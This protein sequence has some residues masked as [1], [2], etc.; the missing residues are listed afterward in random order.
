MNRLAIN[1]LG[2]ELEES[3]AYCRAEGIG[4][5]ITDFAFPQN[6]DDDLVAQIDR[7]VNALTGIEPLISHGPFFDLVVTSIDP[8][9]VGISRQRHEAALRAAKE[10]GVSYYV[11]H[12]NFTPLIRDPSYRG[13]W[14]TRMLNFWLPIADDAGK[15]NIVIC[16]ENLWEP[17]PDIHAE[18]IAQG[19][20]PHL[21]ASFDNGHA[22]VFSDLSSSEWVATLGPVI[23]H[24]HLH[25]NS[26]ELD[27]HKPVGEGVEN[28]DELMASFKTN[29]PQAILVMESDR[30]SDNRLS[31]DRLRALGGK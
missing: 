22:L 16:L 5:E 13:K 9:I 24:S 20:H 6:L 23:A 27:Q 29:S 11:A 15:D 2:E 30:L 4:I 31:I 17:V 12:T 25:D 1:T 8:S 19:N 26:G 3:A 14:N 21:R 10:I 18:L 7:H 28:W